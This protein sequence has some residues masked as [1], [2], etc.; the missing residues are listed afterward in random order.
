MNFDP[1]EKEIRQRWF[2]APPAEWRA[3]I[4]RTVRTANLDQKPVRLE[5]HPPR[6]WRREL[7]WPCREAWAG[8]AAIWICILGLNAA[9]HSESGSRKS[10]KAERQATLIALAERRRELA[11]LLDLQP[12]QPVEPLPKPRSDNQQQSAIV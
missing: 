11:A 6:S 12:P 9:T 7:F 4:L 2:R 10:S 8:L 5:C 1:F 3:S